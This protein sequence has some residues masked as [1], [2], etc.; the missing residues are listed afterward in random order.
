M[1]AAAALPLC[2]AS[3]LS[4]AVDAEHGAFD[5][6]SHS[7]TLLVIRNLAPHACALA[8]LPTLTL[9]SAGGKSL[10]ITRAAPRFMHPGPVIVPLRLAAGAEATAALRWVAGAVYDRGRCYA[11][12]SLGVA[13]GTGTI[14]TGLPARICGPASGVTIEQPPLRLD[15]RVDEASPATR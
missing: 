10:P 15:P 2:R 8:G 5:G 12:A 9:R 14:R 11:V 13:I 6:M 1:P 7:G 4:L 3:D